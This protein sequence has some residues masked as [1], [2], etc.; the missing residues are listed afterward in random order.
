MV[1]Q[2]A[3]ISFLTLGLREERERKKKRK[4]ERRTAALA[5]IYPQYRYFQWWYYSTGGILVPWSSTIVPPL[6]TKS[7]NLWD[8][9]LSKIKK[10]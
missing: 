6:L 8:F 4:R 5:E 1:H 2:H 10:H 3:L 7:L 9:F